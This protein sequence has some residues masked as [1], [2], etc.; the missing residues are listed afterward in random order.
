MMDT[1]N[2]LRCY[3]SQRLQPISFLIGEFAILEIAKR[4]QRTAHIHLGLAIGKK[5]HLKIGKMCF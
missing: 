1:R 3:T 2:S 5:I 4:K